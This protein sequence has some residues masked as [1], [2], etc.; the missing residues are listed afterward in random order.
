MVIKMYNKCLNFLK[1]NRYVDLPQD[2]SLTLIALPSLSM[3]SSIMT[4]FEV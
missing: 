1:I 2:A 4:V 3:L